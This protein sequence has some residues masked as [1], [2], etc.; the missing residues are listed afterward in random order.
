VT[1]QAKEASPSLAV[2]ITAIQTDD[3]GEYVS[4]IQP[5]G[6]TKRVDV[7]SGSIVGNLVAVTGNLEEGD[8]VM[9]AQNNDVGPGGP[10]GGG[11]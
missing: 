4:V 2:P 7:V 6:S 11:N 1:I 9:S 5:N 3:R 8:S 10:F